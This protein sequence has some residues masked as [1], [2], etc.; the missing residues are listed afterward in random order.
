MANELSVLPNSRLRRVAQDCPLL[1]GH[2]EAWIA[3]CSKRFFPLAKQIALDDSAALDILQESWIKVIQAVHA[4]RGG[5]PACAWV[6][7]IVANSAKDIHRRRHGEVE[8]QEVLDLRQSTE[9]SPEDQAM[10]A[11][12]LRLL[13]EIISTL[14]ETYHQVLVLR[15]GQERSTEETAE[16]PIIGH[17]GG[18]AL[19]RESVPLATDLNF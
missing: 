16:L 4:Y 15:Y 17:R 6:R 8:L 19:Y 9:R 14:P 7:P 12:L 1:D 10:E 3:C 2:E 18:R 13:D 5:S 11:Q